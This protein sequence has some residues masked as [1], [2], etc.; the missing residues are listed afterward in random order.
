MP[1]ETTANGEKITHDCSS[2]GVRISN[3]DAEIGAC[4]HGLLC[5]QCRYDNQCL[6]CK[7]ERDE[8]DEA[9]DPN[10]FADNFFTRS[11]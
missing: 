5:N 11:N 9:Y 2:C 1:T 3:W 7:R 8:P 4:E 10:D 6:A